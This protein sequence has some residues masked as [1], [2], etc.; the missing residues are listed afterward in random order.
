MFSSNTMTPPPHTHT[1]MFPI[2]AGYPLVSKQ[3]KRDKQGVCFWWPT[4]LPA[5]GYKWIPPGAPAGPPLLQGSRDNL[6]LSMCHCNLPLPPLPSPPFFLN[7]CQLPHWCSQTLLP[8]CGA[9]HW[10]GPSDSFICVHEKS[11]SNCSFATVSNMQTAPIRGYVLLMLRRTYHADS[12]NND[13]SF[14][15]F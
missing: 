13:G 1:L 4:N 9:K 3:V 15:F 10:P 2:L 8:I 6:N 12:W 7:L 5:S 11:V 14:S